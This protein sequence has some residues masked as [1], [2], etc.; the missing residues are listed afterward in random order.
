MTCPINCT[1]CKAIL[2]VFRQKKRV[3][4]TGMYL[5]GLH[6][7]GVADSIRKF[8]IPG[9]PYDPA[10]FGSFTRNLTPHFNS[11]V[12]RKALRRLTQVPAWYELV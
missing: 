6:P 4:H 12:I 5:D 11:L 8:R 7:R 2:A 1:E 9:R 3:S 10:K